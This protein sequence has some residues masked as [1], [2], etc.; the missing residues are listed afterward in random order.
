MAQLQAYAACYSVRFPQSPHSTAFRLF[1]V[2]SEA[3]VEVSA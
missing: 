2:K 1:E 3:T